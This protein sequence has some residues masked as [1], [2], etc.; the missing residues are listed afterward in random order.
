MDSLWRQA[1]AHRVRCLRLLIVRLGEM[2]APVS[3]VKALCR[4]RRLVS[5]SH[6]TPMRF[7]R[8]CTCQAGG[9]LKCSPQKSRD[10]LYFFL[11]PA[12]HI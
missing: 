9:T 2:Q 8:V 6:H 4:R 7:W 1:Q 5:L 11:S 3:A 12:S 10:S